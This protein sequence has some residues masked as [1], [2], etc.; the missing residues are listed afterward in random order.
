MIEAQSVG[1]GV[2]LVVRPPAYSYSYLMDIDVITREI[3]GSA[4]EVHKHWGPGLYEEIYQKSLCRELLLRKIP[5]VSQ[6][7]MPLL[8]KG[9]SVGNN[10]RLDLMVNNEVIVEIKAVAYLEEIHAAQLLSYMR[11]TKCR[12]GLLINFNV[13]VLKNGIKRMAL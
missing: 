13:P 3:I 8:Y 11:L 10:L 12:T 1:Q 6:M 9:E 4:I 2:S 5:F 7:Q